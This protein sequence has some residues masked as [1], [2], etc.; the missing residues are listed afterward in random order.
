[1][2]SQPFTP[3][4]YKKT[5]FNCPF[6]NAF[7]SQNWCEAA[8][9]HEVMGG[10]KVHRNDVDETYFCFCSHCGKYSVWREQVMIHP[11]FAGIDSPNEDLGEDIV[12]D[13]LEAASIL[14]KSP[15]GAAALLRLAVQKLCIQLGETGKEINTDIANLVTKGLSKTIQQALDTLRV[16]G[17]ESVHPG[18]ID[19]RDDPKTAEALFKILNKIAQTMITEPREIQEIYNKLPEEKKKA[20]E[21]RD[22]KNSTTNP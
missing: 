11:D 15:R 12:E 4:S 14:Q 21:V 5:S 18:Q 1:M 3:P 7:A 20:I 19:L 13:Y 2:S 17:N 6:C 22:A 10:R 9:T 16:I 8:T